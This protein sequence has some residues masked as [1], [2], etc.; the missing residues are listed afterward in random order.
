[1]EL[2]KLQRYEMCTFCN[3][4]NFYIFNWRKQQQGKK[5]TARAREKREGES[6]VFYELVYSY[7]SSVCS[8]FPISI[9][10]ISFPPIQYCFFFFSDK[11]KWRD[12]RRKKRQQSFVSLWFHSNLLSPSFLSSFSWRF[13]IHIYPSDLPHIVWVV[14]ND[15]LKFCFKFMFVVASHGGLEFCAFVSFAELAIL[16]IAWHS[17]QFALA[18]YGYARKKYIIKSNVDR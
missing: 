11:E 13:G 14:Y 7:R 2:V 3:A 8:L 17:I 6:F 18:A 9:S 12:E 15:N 1:M 4:E 5:P 16:T 10:V